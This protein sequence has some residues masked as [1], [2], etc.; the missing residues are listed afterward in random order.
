MKKLPR[1]FY[2]ALR[3]IVVTVLVTAV[4]L[5]AGLYVALL[6]PSVQ[7]RIKNQG[8]KALSEYLGT[9]VSIEK[10]DITPFDQLVLHN[11][12]VPDQAGD[13]LLRVD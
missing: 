9:Q 10:I 3:A 12:L 7:Q 2:N 5:Y 13:S 1:K 11:V 4:A 6:I 8:E